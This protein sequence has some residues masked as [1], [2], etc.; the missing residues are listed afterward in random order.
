MVAGTVWQQEEDFAIQNEMLLILIL[1]RRFCAENRMCGTCWQVLKP[2]VYLFTNK[3]FLYCRV[4]GGFSRFIK[5]GCR[6]CYLWTGIVQPRLHHPDFWGISKK[7]LIYMTTNFQNMNY[8]SRSGAV[9]LTYFGCF[10]IVYVLRKTINIS[11]T[12][13]LTPSCSLHTRYF[14][15]QY[16]IL[17][18]Q[19]DFNF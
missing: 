10:E 3:L 5:W 7:I 19:N 6:G 15:L 11:C 2:S 4:W 17:A 13:H 18:V 12:H 1:V 16:L 14:L 8:V 9:V